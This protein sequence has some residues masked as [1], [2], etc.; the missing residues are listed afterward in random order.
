MIPISI[1]KDTLEPK[2]FF[3]DDGKISGVASVIVL[4]FESVYKKKKL[5]QRSF[6]K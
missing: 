2:L 4:I 5:G 6:E 1:L 3:I